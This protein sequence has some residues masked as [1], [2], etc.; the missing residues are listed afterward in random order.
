M[1]SARP[2]PSVHNQIAANPSKKKAFARH[3]PFGTIDDPCTFFSSRQQLLET[4]SSGVN[5]GEGLVEAAARAEGEEPQHDTAIYW[6]SC[7][8][9]RQVNTIGA[10][11]IDVCGCRA[12]MKTAGCVCVL[13]LE[14]V[15]EWYPEHGCAQSRLEVAHPPLEAYSRLPQARR[16]FQPSR[17]S[18]LPRSITA[19]FALLQ[20][21]SSQTC[22]RACLSRVFFYQ[23]LYFQRICRDFVILR[24]FRPL[25]GC[26]GLIAYS[27]VDHPGLPP[28]PD[29]VRGKLDVS[30]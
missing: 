2:P 6:F 21:V 27:S 30:G 25:P 24:C 3:L 17:T 19:L 9:K 5:T 11:F 29:Y 7:T 1:L 26:G 4:F 16:P 10:S 23:L 12:S 15:K 8:H 14:E 22:I 20:H 28:C 18:P 13:S